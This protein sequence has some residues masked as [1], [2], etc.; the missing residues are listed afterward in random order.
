MTAWCSCTAGYGQT[1]NHIIAVLYKVEHAIA[2]DYHKPACTEISSKW[3]DQT[4]KQVMPKKIKDMDI[5]KDSRLKESSAEEREAKRKSKLHFDP[6]RAGEDMV[7]PEAMGMFLTSLSEKSPKSVIFTGLSYQIGSQLERQLPPS[8]IEVAEQVAARRKT[9]TDA[10][11]TKMFFES[12]EATH[13]QINNIEEA[14]RGQSV[15]EFW[16]TQ[17]KG[18]ITASMCHT[19]Y[20][21]VKSIVRNPTKKQKVSPLVSQIV[22]GGPSL[23]HI[24]AVKWGENTKRMLEKTLCVLRLQDMQTFLLRHVGLLSIRIFLIL[25]PARTESYCVNVVKK[26]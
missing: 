19:I 15:S 5:R 14:S 20:T 8:L 4:Q 11:V 2:S 1:C 12:V 23:D 22:F 13:D 7:K 25:L 18:R 21:K 24:E 3:N 9:E 6:C 10:D 16:N 26:L 17:R